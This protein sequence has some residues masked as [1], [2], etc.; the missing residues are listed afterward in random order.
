MVDVKQFF[1]E[2][3][4]AFTIYVVEQRFAVGRGADYFKSFKGTEKYIDTDR[5]LAKHI[6]GILKW[7]NKRIPNVAGLI[8]S[9]FIC[10]G[11]L[12]LVDIVTELS[13]LFSV[14]SH[15]AAGPD[16][17]DPI[18]IQEGDILSKRLA[19]LIS[20]HKESILSPTIIIILKDNDFERAKDMLS[21]C[22]HGINIKLIRNSGK[23]EIL[24]V[25]NPGANNPDAFIDAFAQQCFS[26]CSH[27]K[28]DVLLNKEWIGESAIHQF[29][30]SLMKIR[31]SLLCDDKI[32]IRTELS[33]IITQ[34]QTT[35]A[36]D[37]PRSQLLYAFQCMALLFRVYCNDSGGQ[38]IDRAYQL[39]KQLNNK[40]LL[41]QVYRYSFFMHGLSFQDKL[42]LLGQA[43][44]IFES[45]DMA[46]HAIYCENNRLVRQ[47]DTD[48][49]DVNAFL[50]LREEAV[51][52]VPGLAGMSHIFNN[53]GVAHLVTGNPADAMES[54]DAG[55]DYTRLPER[56]VQKLAILSN[57]LLAKA[58][59]LQK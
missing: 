30:P 20:L 57:K 34:L 23:S 37:E 51:Y 59:D 48:R 8:K 58:Y 56:S 43:Q 32:T 19:Q 18:I 22:P 6:S 45:N 47:F 24:K 52:N 16:V 7:I 17:L 9:C 14:E 13:K 46:D 11:P 33:D 3:E 53:I 4:S 40:V 21:G 12:G 55:L 26:T 38:D 10:Q 1:K 50:S 2:S 42:D 49:I 15:Q 25:V 27:T 36:G 54:F 29:A 41:A 31:S 44:A 5:K 39:A 28:R 35:S